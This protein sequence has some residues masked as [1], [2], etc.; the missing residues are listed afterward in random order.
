M[1][2]L[3]ETCG[4]SDVGVFGSDGKVM[5][6]K[7]GGCAMYGSLQW[8]LKPCTKTTLALGSPAG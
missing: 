8:S 6:G 1:R 4:V 7:G 2:C 3:R 5:E